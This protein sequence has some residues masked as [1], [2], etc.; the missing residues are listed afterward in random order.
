M[1]TITVTQLYEQL[2]THMGK[3]TAEN[4]CSYV[5]CKISEELE[6][7]TKILATRADVEA[8]RLATKADVEALRLATKADVAALKSDI[9]DLR[10][11]T[12]TDLAAEAAA[13]RSEIVDFKLEFLAKLGEYKA[14]TMRWM[15]IFWVGQVTVTVSLFMFF[16]RK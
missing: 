5:N 1:N 3:E 9:A 14:D 8:L 7:Q 11:A 12:K 4:L 15:F 10:L 13:L 2:T 6:D 16:L